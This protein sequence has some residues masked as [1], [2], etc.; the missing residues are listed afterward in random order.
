MAIAMMGVKQF[1]N[2]W[3][4]K[5]IAALHTLLLRNFTFCHCEELKA[6]AAVTEIATTPERR[7]AMTVSFVHE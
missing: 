7:L 6:D 4:F 1:R 3:V 5:E 2:R